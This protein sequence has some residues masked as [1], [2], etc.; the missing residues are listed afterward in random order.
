MNFGTNIKRVRTEKGISQEEL[1]R[2][3]SVH[4]NQLSKYERDQAA[5]SIEVVQR[6][7]EALEVSIDT[8][9][10]GAEQKLDASI[11]DRELISLFNRVQ[12]LSDRQKD[13]VKD[14]LSA[15]VLK[16]DLKEKLTV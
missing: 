5:P 7:A 12:L 14:F 4:P 16:Q 15:F 6:M 13:T 11:S 9:V 1:G 8:L 2:R 10:F 3:I